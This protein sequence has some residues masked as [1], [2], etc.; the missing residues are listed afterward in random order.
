MQCGRRRPCVRGTFAFGLH[1]PPVSLFILTAAPSSLAPSPSGWPFRKGSSLMLECRGTAWSSFNL[2]E[3]SLG[4]TDWRLR[5]SATWHL[6]WAQ[7][8]TFLSRDTSPLCELP[9][10]GEH[11]YSSLQSGVWRPLLVPCLAQQLSLG[12]GPGSS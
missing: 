12:R 7:L 5:V 3:S 6:S 11:D 10:C 2:G 4:C 9:L 8:L 1:R